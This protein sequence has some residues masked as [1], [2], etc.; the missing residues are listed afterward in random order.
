MGM[1]QRLSRG[2]NHGVQARPIHTKH[3]PPPPCSGAELLPS[4]ED[5]TT[6]WHLKAVVNESIALV[7]V[8]FGQFLSTILG[9]NLGFS[10]SG[11]ATLPS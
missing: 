11:P 1:L 9:N 3:H 7:N 8:L 5:V 10:I 6:I 4:G 2:D